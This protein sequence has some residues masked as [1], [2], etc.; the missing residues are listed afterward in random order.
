MDRLGCAGEEFVHFGSVWPCAASASGLALGRARFAA[1][2]L[3]A[4]LALTVNGRAL[5]QQPPQIL[6]DIPAQPLASALDAY[7]ATTGLM[8]VYNGNLAAG[9]LSNAIRG[10]LTPQAALPLL[11]KGTGLV[12]EY[13]SSEAFVVVPGLDE[14][15]IKLPSAIASAAIARQDAIERRYSAMMQ[16][17]VTDALCAQPLTR[18][19]SYR[20]AISFWI[21][22][23]GE[24]L[25][26]KL[27]SSTGDQQRDAAIL[28][29]AGRASVGEPPPARM[30]QPFTMV[31]L[32]QSSGGTIDCP[33][34]GR[35]QHG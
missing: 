32:P 24:M 4:P 28:D 20:A 25:R 8:A 3:M 33:V 10:R 11:L 7:S 30:A 16:D 35:R 31:V 34:E 19:G 13:T 14:S 5:A 29:V 6:F 23:G 17:S 15:L 22:A 27:L 1:C 18:P 26:V 12:A 9:R 2:L 21:G